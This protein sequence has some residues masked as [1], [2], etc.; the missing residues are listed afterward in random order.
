MGG[1]D[2]PSED[3]AENT[4]EG[5]DS[6]KAATQIAVEAN[7]VYEEAA[8]S[9]SGTANGGTSS[10]T[11]PRARTKLE[12]ADISLNDCL[13]CSGCVTSAESVL[14]G[15]QSLEEVRRIVDENRTGAA[16]QR[17]MVASIAPQCLASLSARHSLSTSSSGTLDDS[18][19]PLATLLHRLAYFLRSSFNFAAVTDTTFARHVALREH[20][21]EFT[22]RRNATQKS[23]TQP[24]LPMLASACPGWICYAEKTHG[25]LLPFVSK[26]K[27]P[28]QVAGS[29]F[30]RWFSAKGDIK[31][32]DIYHVAVMPCYDKKL[33]AS[34]SDFF[35]DIL[36]T[37]DVDCVITTGELDRLMLEE[38]FD[39]TLPVPGENDGALGLQ[40]P[41]SVLPSLIDHP[42]S[43]SGSY[44]FSL[45]E[46]SWREYLAISADAACS[47]QMDVR[48]IRT[49]DFTEY[50]LRSPEGKILFKGAHCYGFRNL[51]NLVRKVQKQTGVKSRK[52]GA[53]AIAS[54]SRLS[55]AANGSARG[56]GARGGM[57]KRGGMMRQ[58]AGAVNGGSSADVSTESG[59]EDSESRGYDYVEVM[60]CPSGCVNGGGQLRP[61]ATAEDSDAGRQGNGISMAI[62]SGLVE[63]T[64]AQ[65]DVAPP[66]AS[67]VVPAAVSKTSAAM[68][69][70][71]EGYSSGWSTPLSDRS[72]S[73]LGPDEPPMTQ[74]WQGTSK[75]WVK[76][77]ERAYWTAS[78]GS[79]QQHEHSG[80]SSRQT[81]LN[82]LAHVS[83]Q[84]GEI[85]AL[86]ERIVSELVAASQ[87]LG[88]RGA[89]GPDS[90][91]E[92]LLRTGYRAI[93]DEAVSGLA[94]QW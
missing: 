54:S 22:E 28:Q 8:P 69:L 76:R 66:P 50:I 27:S 32:S 58:G 83:R 39:I 20:Q 7:G 64:E 55:G 29:L 21:L 6:Q 70:D 85:D 10:S 15:M 2:A 36:A 72:Q 1:A 81:L 82:A 3:V 52:G 65:T 77:V 53:A 92:R 87:S 11:A 60:A 46:A 34:R 94:V 62:S 18:F 45:I 38:G 13:A 23:P 14:I 43:S 59:V 25:E 88:G 73:Q 44:L 35:D 86:A 51:Q 91:R 90:E 16:P 74:G 71:P 26:T 19:V 42:G 93:Q 30:K 24:Q 80:D 37:K 61:P 12:A 75:E 9:T 78:P 4:N 17:T 89:K 79:Q 40:T 33:E 48:I 41:S 67:S 84:P 68:D 63:S 56:R 47:P 31:P 49:S 5:D 57:M